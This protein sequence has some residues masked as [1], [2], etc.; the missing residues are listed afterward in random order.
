[1]DSWEFMKLKKL[2]KVQVIQ[3]IQGLSVTWEL[4]QVFLELHGD[5]NLLLL[6]LS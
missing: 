4:V 5:I 1:M 3:E 2:Y 6:G